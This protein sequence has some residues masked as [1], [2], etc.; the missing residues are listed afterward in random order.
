MIKKTEIAKFNQM[1]FIFKDIIRDY[2]TLS[3]S[4]LTLSR[5]KTQKEASKKP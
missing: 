5:M 4:T 2:C 3:S 1:F